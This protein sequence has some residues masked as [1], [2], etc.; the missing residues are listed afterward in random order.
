MPKNQVRTQ[1]PSGSNTLDLDE[2]FGVAKSITVRHQGRE[3][4]LRPL[5]ALSPEETLRLT[6]LQ[7]RYSQ[8][9][10]RSKKAGAEMFGD[11]DFIAIVDDLLAVVSPDLAREQLTFLKKISVLG[12]Y[13][14]STSPRVSAPKKTGRAERIGRA[15]SPA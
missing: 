5:D 4:A 11:R 6:Q 12:F 8:A 13:V 7:K 3:F 15:S 1:A 14:R 2:L 9:L 10:A